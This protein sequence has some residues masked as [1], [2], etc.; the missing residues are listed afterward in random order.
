MIQKLDLDALRIKLEAFA[1]ERDWA[2]FHTPKNLAMALTVEA[3]ELLELFQW[4]GE[5]EAVSEELKGRVGEELSDILVYLLRLTHVLDIDLPAVLAQK[6]K[7]N[8]EKYPADLV[9]GSSKKYDQY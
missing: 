4:M 5:R 9:R 2:Q 1:D 8:E 3:S 7:K 6:I